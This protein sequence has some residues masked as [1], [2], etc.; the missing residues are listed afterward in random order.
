MS[1]RLESGES[2]PTGIKRIIQE[3][4][5]DALEHLTEPGDDPIDALLQQQP[6]L[7]EDDST[8]HLIFGLVDQEG[9]LLETAARPFWERIYV[10]A[11]QVFV[12]RIAGYW[13]V[14]R[15]DA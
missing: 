15:Q 7:I 1:Y 12:G 6:A 4:I 2:L 3:Q 10:E 5:S 11:P 9:Q 14:A 8:R 13:Q